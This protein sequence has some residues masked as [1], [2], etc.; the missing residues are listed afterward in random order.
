MKCLV[1]AGNPV[2]AMRWFHD[3]YTFTIGSL[4]LVH[5]IDMIINLTSQYI[6]ACGIVPGVILFVTIVPRPQWWLVM[7]ALDK[8]AKE[9]YESVESKIDYRK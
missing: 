1:S 7:K 6:Y 9:I 4:I 2:V 8:S 3:D 5:Y